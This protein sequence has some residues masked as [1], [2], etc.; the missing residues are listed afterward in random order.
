MTRKSA[1]FSSMWVAAV[2]EGMRVDSLLDAGHGV[3]AWEA[4]VDPPASLFLLTAP[5]L[6]MHEQRCS[7]L[8]KILARRTHNHRA[9]E[10]SEIG[11]CGAPLVAQSDV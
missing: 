1:P 3:P 2:P 5:L 11:T 4:R 6:T 9:H 10:D 8:L 7:K